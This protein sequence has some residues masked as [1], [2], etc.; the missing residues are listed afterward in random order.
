MSRARGWARPRC[1]LGPRPP[2]AHGQDPS[3]RPQFATELG[4]DFGGAGARFPNGITL[5]AKFDGEFAS[6]PSTCPACTFRYSW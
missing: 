1:R 5:L 3:G 6:H 4:A 2:F